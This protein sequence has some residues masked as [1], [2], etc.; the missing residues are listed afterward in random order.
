MFNSF[1]TPDKTKGAKTRHGKA[2]VPLRH[3]I[4]TEIPSRMPPK[5]PLTQTPL[6]HRPHALRR[7]KAPLTKIGLNSKRL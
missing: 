5:V 2:G 6:T 1:V 7:T 3:Q 4:P